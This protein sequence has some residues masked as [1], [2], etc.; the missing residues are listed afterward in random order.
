M[1]SKNSPRRNCRIEMRTNRIIW[2]EPLYQCCV[3][4]T[5][6]ES[7]L[8]GGARKIFFRQHRPGAVIWSRCADEPEF[9]RYAN[10][11][12][13]RSV[14]QTWGRD[15]IQ[16]LVTLTEQPFMDPTGNGRVH[17][18]DRSTRGACKIGRASWRER[19]EN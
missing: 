19:E 17:V 7:I 18:M 12:R 8:L 13:W 4:E 6:L 1:R 16:G 3:S 10:G 5:D 14:S 9:N 11:Q 15:G 2:V